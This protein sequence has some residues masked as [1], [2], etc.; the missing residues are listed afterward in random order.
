VL[1]LSGSIKGLSAVISSAQSGQVSTL[2][3]VSPTRFATKSMLV[4]FAIVIT[5]YPLKIEP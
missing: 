2:P 4:K 1:Y 5:S 3:E